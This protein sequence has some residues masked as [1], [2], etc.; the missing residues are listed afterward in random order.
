[1]IFCN[2][3]GQIE[4]KSDFE[5]RQGLF[6]LFQYDI[7]K[8]ARSKSLLRLYVH[9]RSQIISRMKDSASDQLCI[10]WMYLRSWGPSACHNLLDKMT[11]SISEDDYNS[12]L[13]KIMKGPDED[14]TEGEG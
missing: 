6:S 4:Q 8:T 9:L 14:S 10:T 11:G 13:L 7:S 3:E 2:Y 12:A 1:M 5:T